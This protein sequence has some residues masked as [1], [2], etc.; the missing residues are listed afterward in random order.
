MDKDNK[1]GYYVVNKTTMKVLLILTLLVVV[2]AGK[3]RIY[4]GGGMGFKL[5]AKKSFSFKDTIVNM[6]DIFG[7]PLIAV[8]SL[9]PAVR[10]QLE[11][12]GIIETGDKAK[13]CE[14]N[15]SIINKAVEA[16][17]FVEATWPKEDLP[18]IKKNKNYFPDGIP[19][20]PVD[21]TSYVLKP[22]PYH[23]VLGHRIGIGT[24]E[25]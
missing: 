8:E 15:R 2:I 7:M 12:M 22:S 18:D 14:M 10:R 13:S 24:H 1:T 16:Y 21:Q 3:L 6:D 4:Y 19:T 25:Y 11:D 20:C 9:H 23:R 5:V 17:Y